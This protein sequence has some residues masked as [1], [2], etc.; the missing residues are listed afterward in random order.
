M[1]LALEVQSFNHWV[2]RN[3]QNADILG[4]CFPSQLRTQYPLSM[5]TRVLSCF[6]RVL[7]LCNPMHCSPLGS[8]VYEIL[9]ARIVSGLP[10]APP[11]VLPDPGN[12]TLVSCCRQ[13]LYC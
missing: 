10:C 12:L 6:G 8:S 5:I 13:I 9:Q 2:T 11:E 3:S 1:L 7:L 4:S